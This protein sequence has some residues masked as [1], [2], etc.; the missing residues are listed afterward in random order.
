MALEQDDL[1]VM[2]GLVAEVVDQEIE[3]QSRAQ[4]E[5]RREAQADAAL[6]HHQP[7]GVALGAAVEGQRVDRR[8]LGRHGLALAVGRSGAGVNE[9]LRRRQ[10]L[11]QDS[12]AVDV[13][14]LGRRRIGGARGIADDRG[15]VQHDV[16]RRGQRCHD[17]RIADVAVHD[18]ELRM[19][20]EVQD[21][22]HAEHQ[23]V[24]E[25][26]LVP[27]VQQDGTEKRS[28]IPG[29]AGD[30]DAHVASPP[31]HRAGASPKSARRLRRKL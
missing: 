20:D 3:A 22:L 9:H 24:E 15:E 19:G 17:P 16:D 6:F 1:L 11:D 2:V 30:E 13:G 7:L 5:D 25:D 8:L 31:R 29:S 18:L 26:H 4:A 27:G 14:R 28:D 12:R 10:R 23:A 21:R